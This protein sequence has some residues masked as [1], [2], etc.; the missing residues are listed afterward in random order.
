MSLSYPKHTLKKSRKFEV[1]DLVQFVTN[2]NIDEFG[3]WYSVGPYGIVVMVAPT[4]ET[5][6]VVWIGDKR[7][8]SIGC[9]YLQKIS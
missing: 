8:Y 6:K 3:A 2:S 9:N 4:Y 7:A 5:A 1:G